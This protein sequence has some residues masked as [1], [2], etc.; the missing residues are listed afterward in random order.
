METAAYFCCTRAADG[1]GAGTAV[2]ITLDRGDL[3]LD[4][5]GLGPDR[6]EHQA[7]V[8]RVEAAGGSVSVAGTQQDRHVQVRLPGQAAD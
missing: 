5:R 4:L 3:V 6:P 1:A 8:D 2:D 7:M